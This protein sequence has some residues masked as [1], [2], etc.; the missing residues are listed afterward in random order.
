MTLFAKEVIGVELDDVEIR[1]VGLKKRQD[2][3]SLSFAHRFPLGEN[4]IVD[5]VVK[6]PIEVSKAIKAFW[7]EKKLKNKNIIVGISNQAVMIR[8]ILLPDIPEDKIKQLIYNHAQEYMPIPIEN[9]VIDYMVV[10]KK[11]VQSV[12]NLEVLLVAAQLDMVEDLFESFNMANLKPKDIKPSSLTSLA[13]FNE[14][15]KEGIF[16]LVDISNNMGTLTLFINGQPHLSRPLKVNFN[17]STGL[18]PAKEE[19]IMELSQA[20]LSAWVK[21]LDNEIRTSIRYFQE[22]EG[23]NAVDGIKISGCGSRVG[24]LDLGLEN[25]LDIP[26]KFVSPLKRIDKVK[27]KDNHELI[28]DFTTCI[29]LALVG[30]E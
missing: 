20:A 3:I 24:G 21:T 15:D 19:S 25:S 16:A 23:I 18:Y 14:K 17:K 6:E 11:Q 4:L 22:Q 2:R 26:V 28:I 9:A 8:K 27:S 13:V 12:Q 10:G 30:L 1:V 29:G 7:I 5:G